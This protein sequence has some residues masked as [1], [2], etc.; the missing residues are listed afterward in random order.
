MAIGLRLGRPSF[1]FFLFIKSI[2]GTECNMTIGA[3]QNW[4]YIALVVFNIT[5]KYHPRAAMF[6][7][8]YFWNLVEL[9]IVSH[10]SF[11]LAN[12]SAFFINPN[13]TKSNV[14][15]GSP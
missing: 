15:L 14:F 10:Y 12:G 9:C 5:V 7:H 1:A 6:G 4:S 8:K 11:L 3:Q 2:S 13:A